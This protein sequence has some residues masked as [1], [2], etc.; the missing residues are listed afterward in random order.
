MLAAM[1]ALAA[2]SLFE[3]VLVGGGE[4]AISLVGDG[5]TIDGVE[6]GGAEDGWAVADNKVDEN[7]SLGPVLSR[8]PESRQ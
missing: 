1:F 8:P 7:L 5:A 4:V 6:S 3:P 2:S